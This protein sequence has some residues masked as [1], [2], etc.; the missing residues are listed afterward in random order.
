[1]LVAGA[2]L[3]GCAQNPAASEYATVYFASA[4]GS[5]VRVFE[6]S[7]REIGRFVTDYGEIDGPVAVLVGPLWFTFAC[8][9]ALI[10]TYDNKATV[11]VQTS[12]EYYLYCDESGK[13]LIA[14]RK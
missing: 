3:A 7:D 13:L 10:E 6:Y 11:E 8:P 12:G 1:M 2:G 5:R 14:P 4:D 9:R